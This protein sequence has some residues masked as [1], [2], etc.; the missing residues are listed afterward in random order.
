[1]DYNLGGYTKEEVD[2]MLAA[3]GLPFYALGFDTGTKEGLDNFGAVARGSGGAIEIVSEATVGEALSR[4]AEGVNRVLVAEF[5]TDS[6]IIENPVE[7]FAITL[8]E[9]TASMQVPLR[10]WQPDTE[11]PRVLGI[12]QRTGESIWLSFSEPVQGAN[13]PE[14]F[15]VTNAAG[16]LLGVSAA[17]YDEG[18]RSVTLT[19]LEPPLTGEYGIAFP[20]VTDVSAEANGIGGDS[21]FSFEG[22]S[23]PKLETF[24]EPEGMPVGFW[25]FV[26]I[27]GVLIIIGIVALTIA[28]KK[29]AQSAAQQEV[30]IPAGI[31]F[32]ELNQQVPVGGEMQVHFQQADVPLPK[33]K[34]HVT[35]PSGEA[36]VVEM[37]INK[38]LF[39]GRSDICDVYFDDTAMSRQHF[40]I[41]EDHGVYTLTNLSET[42]G[43]TLNGVKLSNPRPLSEGDTIGAGRQRIVFY[44]SGGL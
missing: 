9:Q 6:N 22:D 37:P 29:K 25:I 12:E 3:T 35:G 24:P 8:G 26:S 2:K 34:L 40:V 15:A 28:R 7:E 14:S 13:L 30:A 10:F 42:G 17:A 43:T 1:V 21:A 5:A 44:T 32:M 4:M 36:K 23:L 33:I 38:T 18:E 20:G 11:A 27:L 16:D 19:F 31:G 41:G 39:V